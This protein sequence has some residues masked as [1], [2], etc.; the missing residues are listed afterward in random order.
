MV[1]AATLERYLA[2]IRRMENYFMGFTVEYVERAK[3]IEADKLAKAA[4]KKETLQ[5][6]VF[7]QIIE[8]PSVQG[9]DW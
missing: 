7:L 9:E 2:I 5:P 8:D 1:R 4:T 3:N 6:E